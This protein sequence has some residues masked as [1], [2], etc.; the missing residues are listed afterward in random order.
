MG[1]SR[2]GLVAAAAVG[3]S[4]WLDDGEC[5][6][7]CPLAL[8]SKGKYRNLRQDSPKLVSGTSVSIWAQLAFLHVY[9]SSPTEIFV[10]TVGF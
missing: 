10:M 9:Q 6:R 1:F 4:I 8:H 3:D 5:C 2:V 7:R